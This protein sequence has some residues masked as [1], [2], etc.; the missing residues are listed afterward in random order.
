VSRDKLGRCLRFAR[1]GVAKVL[2]SWK[3]A[4][5]SFDLVSVAIC[6]AVEQ[7]KKRLEGIP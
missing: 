5:I 4:V 1:C 2:R 3:I 7:L 6:T